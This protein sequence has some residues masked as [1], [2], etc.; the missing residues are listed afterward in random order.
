MERLG[1]SIAGA[2]TLFQQRVEPVCMA[3]HGA[4]RNVAAGPKLL[5]FLGKFLNLND[6]VPSCALDLSCI[7]PID[8]FREHLMRSK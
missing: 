6:A 3:P 4:P 5:Q 1:V 8:V 7:T 2:S